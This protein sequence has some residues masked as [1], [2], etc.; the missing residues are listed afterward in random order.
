MLDV[1]RMKVLR[2]V[3]ER[4]S[5][6]AAA[7]AL[8]FTQSAISQHV[9]ALERETGARLVERGARGVRLTDAGRALVAHT[10]AILTRLDAEG[11]IVTLDRQDRG[12]WDTREIT[13]G[14][15]VLQSVLATEQRGRYQIEA[16]IAALHD[17][18]GTVLVAQAHDVGDVLRRARQEQEVRRCRLEAQRV[19]RMM[20]RDV[21]AEADQRGVEQ[22]GEAVVR[23]GQHRSFPIA[24]RPRLRAVRRWRPAAS[25]DAGAR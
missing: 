18:A 15:R 6:S 11:R 21:V 25:G 23:R 1:R 4:G 5:F 7:E 3:A 16:A 12:L 8:N 19:L 2:E 13:E 10:E 17:D 22:P 14:V 9:A 24:R 20:R